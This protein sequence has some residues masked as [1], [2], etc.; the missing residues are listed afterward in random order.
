MRRW[1]RYY[2]EDDGD[3]DDYAQ[4]TRVVPWQGGDDDDDDDDQRE[5][6]HSR[7][8]PPR[9]PIP[10]PPTRRDN[11]DD[12]DGGGDKKEVVDDN[13]KEEDD[14]GRESEDLGARPRK[15][16]PKPK[17]GKDDVSGALAGLL[18]KLNVSAEDG[19][20]SKGGNINVHLHLE[21][22]Y[23]ENFTFSKKEKGGGRRH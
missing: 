16:Y 12:D 20:D 9:R 21:G 23:F 19:H 10:Q 3:D 5:R 15:V 17:D 13:D 8:P 7:A 4:R 6:G 14:D 18:D 11:P 2:D 1:N 22:N